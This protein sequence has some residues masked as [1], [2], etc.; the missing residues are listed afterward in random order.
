MIIGIVGH[1]VKKFTAQTEEAARTVIRFILSQKDIT[2]V[3][4]GGCHLGGVDI[5]AIEEAKKLGLVTKEFLPKFKRWEPNGYK[6]RNIAIARF[7][8]EVHCI[9]VDR[10]PEKYIGMKWKE[11]YHCHDST[12]VK[13]GGCWTALHARGLGKRAIWHII[14]TA[15]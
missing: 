13:S 12:H 14:A 15:P 9:V 11:C 8:D 10:L 5:W 3:A 4:S 1:E 2:T 7:C 6:A